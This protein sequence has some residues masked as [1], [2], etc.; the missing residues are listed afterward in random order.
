MPLPFPF[1]FKK[2]DYV[3]VFDWRI[4][5]LTR[6][7]KK[8]IALAGLR[9]FYKENPA[10]FIIDWGV[11]FDPRNVEVGLPTLMPFFLFPKQEEWVAWFMERWKNKEPGITEKSR[12]MGMSWLTVAVSSTICLFNDGV[13]AGFGSRKEE[14]VDKK[15]DPKSLL[16]K[17]RQFVANIPEEFRPGYDERKHAPYMRL[18]FPFT[19]SVIAGESGDGIGRGARA[20]FYFV[21]EAQP[22]D[23]KILTPE[24]WRYMREIDIGDIITGMNGKPQNVIGINNVGEHIVYK[25]SFSDGTTAKCSPNHLWTVDKVWG[26]K[27]R[28]TL[29]AKEIHK[30]YIYHSPAGQT[31]Y[32]YKL[33]KNEAIEF[34]NNTQL[35]LHPYLIGALLGDGSLSKT[36]VMFT[37]ADKEIIDLISILLPA[38]HQIKPSSK[39]NYYIT[40]DNGL[41]QASPDVKMELMDA[42]KSLRM[43]GCRSWEKFIPEMYM[44]SSIEN[45]TELLRGLLDTDGSCSGGRIMFGSSS[46]VMGEQVAELVRSLGG[47]ATISIKPDARGYRDQYYIHINLAETG[48]IPFHLTRKINLLKPAKHLFRKAIINIEILLG[49]EEVKCITVENKDG[50]YITDGY[51]VT[52]NSAWMP[53]PELIDASLSQTTNCRIDVSTPRG[54]N[55]PFARKRFGG[56][57]SVFSCHWREDPRKDQA[58]Y[59][60]TCK[61]IDNPVVIAQEVNLDYSASVE[62]IVIP[63]AW[64]Q[65]A[66]DAHIKLGITPS[67]QR[68]AGLD[69]ADEG[70]DKNAYCGRYGILLEY[71]E[72][73]SGKGSDIFETI[74]KAFTLCD[75]LGYP[76]VYY[77]ADGL[78][79]GARGDAKRINST[80]LHEIIFN[81]FRGSGEVLDKENYPFSTGEDGRN[82]ERGP[83]NEDFFG[84]FKAQ[85]W[86]ALRTR[87]QKTHR[88]ITQGIECNPDEIISISSHIAEFSALI[89]E[90]SQPTYYQNDA[91]KIIVDKIADGGLSPNRADSV[92]IAFAPTP[93]ERRSAFI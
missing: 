50:L 20:S 84:N 5:N 27:E 65:S 37:S 57:I 77:D 63:S 67:G 10:Q 24:G 43:K 76:E 89:T 42:L 41:R 60:K 53:R 70:K 52:H 44:F 7:R 9:A 68:K 66:I 22:L 90:L 93:P 33:P 4:E 75:V 38:H 25:L 14:Y 83:T 23:A 32:I 69:I 85:G 74:Q 72:I 28:L 62:G 48:I 30:K 55:N 45:R 86:W 21:D 8:P 17:A 11:T 56:A 34:S 31:Q 80:R 2:P 51:S 78:G 15:G 91:G 6:L 3:Q 73:W 29:R 12:E 16:Y 81:P 64:V 35:P 47:M 61:D 36:S 46:K 1:D 26:K 13:V 58:W 92:M 18:E 54:M 79:A 88:W 39:Y 59:D 19:G 49:K 71:L 40:H 82:R 87:F